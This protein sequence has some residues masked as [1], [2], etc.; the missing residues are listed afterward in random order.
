MM[1]E[2]WGPWCSF[3][4]SATKAVRHFDQSLLVNPL[5]EAHPAS[6]SRVGLA[7]AVISDAWVV[8]AL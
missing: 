8:D 4:L 3:G 1:Q 2:Q 6:G 5:C 7:G